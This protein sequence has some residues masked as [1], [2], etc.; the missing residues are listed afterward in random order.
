MRVLFWSGPFWPS[1]GGVEIFATKVLTPL[2]ERGYELIVVTDQNEPCLPST[3]LYGD[4]PVY[5][6]SFR[7][8]TPDIDQLTGTRQQVAKLKR[9]FA[10]DLIHINS[11]NPVDFYHH[12]T[13]SAHPAPVLVTLHGIS[14]AADLMRHTLRSASWVVGCSQAILDEGRRMVP[15]IVPRSSVIYN[16][17]DVSAIE[18]AP[19]PLDPPCLLCMGRLV[20]GKGFAVALAALA[21]LADRYPRIRMVV[22][23]DGESR[24]DLER[25]SVELGLDHI[26]RFLGWV[27][28]SEV[29]ALLNTA[30]I[31]LVPSRREESFGLV[32]LEAALMARPVVATSVGGIPEVVANGRTGL[33]VEDGDSEAL[34][35][36]I[37]TLL[38]HP[39]TAAGMGLEARRRAR[40]LFSL[41]RCVDAYDALYRRLIIE[42]R[43][44]G[45]ESSQGGL[46]G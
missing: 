6:L 9:A 32:A 40:E 46:A 7:S 1:I 23:G 17:R 16:G 13:A 10:P 14:R 43:E 38:D 12:V 34:A 21:S 42:S 28:P 39:K 24:R 19:L 27:V 36:A 45:V 31:V 33:L 20:E 5:R 4:I 41:E 26:V 8:S 22:A 2:R 11:V 25:K 37:A 35:G 18:P 3:E 15:E 44:A 29:P 30:A